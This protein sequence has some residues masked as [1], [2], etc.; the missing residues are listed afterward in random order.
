M[1][2]ESYYVDTPSAGLEMISEMHSQK[3]QKSIH[4]QPSQGNIS[5]L[6]S[7]GAYK[8]FAQERNAELMD[9]LEDLWARYDADQDGYLV[10]E[11]T[12]VLYADLVMSH[13]TEMGLEEENH[14]NW[15]HQIDQDYDGRISKEEMLEYLLSIN[16]MV[17]AQVNGFTHD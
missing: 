13:G 3:S 2:D 15:F 1:G 10:L 5:E 6:K 8:D 16:Y 12:A 4:R 7:A 9:Y 11:E 14:N 17:K